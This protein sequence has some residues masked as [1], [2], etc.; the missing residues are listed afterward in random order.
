MRV[1]KVSVVIPIYNVEQYLEDCLDSVVAQSLREIEIVCVN[2]GSS[3]G[4]RAILARYEA[5]D[6]RIRI[7]DQT[8]SGPGSARNAGVSMA[9]GEY[10]YFLDSDDYI[11][12]FALEELYSRASTDR[13]DVLYFDGEVFFEDDEVEAAHPEEA[14]YFR[15]TVEYDGVMTGRELFTRMSEHDDHKP[16]PPM[17]FIRLGF[18][19]TAGLSFYEGIVHEDNLFSF[20]CALQAERAGCTSRAYFHRRL[21]RQ[22]IVTTATGLKNF[23]GHLVTYVEMVRF[24]G[25]RVYDEGTSIAIAQL[26]AVIYH[27]A[28]KLYCSMLPEEREAIDLIDPR[29]DALALG[30]VIKHHADE[31]LRVRQLKSQLAQTEGRWPCCRASRAHRLARALRRMLSS[32]KPRRG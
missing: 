19:R 9:S 7:V 11:D 3:D 26:I 8:N 15:R 22:S 17:Q 31:I 12:T 1:P 24:V 29:P 10:V 21:R 20:L 25:A 23:R 6:S 16:M 13:L 32:V 27:Q 28:L 14:A 4:S 18:Y 5:D 30:D 2:D